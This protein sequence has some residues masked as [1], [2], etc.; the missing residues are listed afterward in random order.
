MVFVVMS[1]A[2]PK[3]GGGNSKSPQIYHAITMP[4]C[5]K[6]FRVRIPHNRRRGP[7]IGYTP[8]TVRTTR[9]QF[10]HDLGRTS[11]AAWLGA[12]L[13]LDA[14]ASPAGPKP[15]GTERGILRVKLLATRLDA[16]AVFYSETMGWPV[17]RRGA[18]LVVRAGGTEIVFE[19]SPG[20][21]APYYHLAWAI[22]SNKFSA[23]KVWL[24]GRTPILR[25]PDGRDEFHFRTARRRAVYFGDPAGNIL[26]LI[27]RDDLGDIAAGGFGLGDLLYVNHAG[28]VVDDMSAAIRTISG[29]LGLEPTAPPEPSFTKLGDAYRH[30]V[31]VPK[32]RLW[33]PKMNRGAEVFA[34][35]VVMHGPRAATLAFDRLPYQIA[36][37]S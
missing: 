24:A 25:H 23:G 8:V 34:A 4:W 22:P 28:L 10:F 26:E 36:I 37:E 3:Y 20:D 6:G 31:L 1:Q 17:A 30:V 5:D 29:S 7:P 14:R 33:L 16:M 13:A 18:A 9:R 27:A 19:P 32:D 12:E 35:E 11:L 15:T 2:L 21:D